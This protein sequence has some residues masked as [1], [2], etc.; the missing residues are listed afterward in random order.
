MRSTASHLRAQKK[1]GDSGVS[2]ESRP[3]REA[4]L[5]E[6]TVLT[7]DGITPGIFAKITGVLAALR[8]QIVGADIVT[9]ADGITGATTPPSKTG[10]DS[11]PFQIAISESGTIS[12][13]K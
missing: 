6:I 1:M 5:T 13:R 7:R 12:F 11:T 9:R 2:V 10:G 8:F 4:G 3:L